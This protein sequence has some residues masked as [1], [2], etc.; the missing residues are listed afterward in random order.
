MVFNTFQL[1]FCTCRNIESKSQT[2]GHWEQKRLH[3]ALTDTAHK[4]TN[5]FALGLQFIFGNSPDTRH[6]IESFL[7]WAFDALHDSTTKSQWSIQVSMGHVST[8]RI[9]K[10]Q[11]HGSGHSCHRVSQCDTCV[12]DHTHNRSNK[13]KCGSLVIPVNKAFKRLIIKTFSALTNIGY[14]TTWIANYVLTAKN[15]VELL[16]SLCS[17]MLYDIGVHS[18]ISELLFSDLHFGEVKLCVC[19]IGEVGT[20]VQ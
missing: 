12:G 6:P 11:V 18:L 20:Q 10:P 19:D 9:P 17:V 1:L 13:A 5:T 8:T 3:L 2:S 4:L 14:E 7:D 15:L 16:H